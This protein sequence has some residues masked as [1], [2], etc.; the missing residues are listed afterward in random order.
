MKKISLL[1]F[2][3][4]IV[5]LVLFYP[6][7]IYASIVS[8]DSFADYLL[9]SDPVVLSPSEKSNGSDGVHAIEVTFDKT[10]QLSPVGKSNLIRLASELRDFP[11]YRVVIKGNG[12]GGGA[13]E[14]DFLANIQAIKSFM[15]G[16][17][18]ISENRFA[19][20]MSISGNSRNIS[21]IPE[22]IGTLQPNNNVD[23]EGE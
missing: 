1:S 8:T 5:S 20:D 4:F 16:E 7:P 10:N 18:G 9:F 13:T 19:I 14:K 23:V 11:H 6:L 17:L 15:I 3:H 22:P 21:L 12:N 2:V